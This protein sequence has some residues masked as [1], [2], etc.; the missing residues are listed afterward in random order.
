MAKV[1]DKIINEYTEILKNITFGI[2]IETCFHILG[3]HIIEDSSARKNFYNCMSRKSKD[4]PNIFQ[5]DLLSE[6]ERST[7]YDHWIIMPDTSVRCSSKLLKKKDRICMRNGVKKPLKDCDDIYFY[8]VEIVTPKLKIGEKGVDILYKVWQ[9]WLFTDNIVYTVNDSQ[10]LHINISHP[11]MNPENFLRWWTAFEPVII[12]TLP[13]S[14]R[15][16]LYTYARPISDV[17]KIGEEK[18]PDIGKNI[19]IN[20]HKNRDKITRM[21]I[22]IGQGTVDFWEAYYW[23]MLCILFLVITINLK[24]ESLDI[25]YIKHIRENPKI[26]VKELLGLISDDSIQRMI[27]N[28]YNLNKDEN[29]PEIYYKPSNKHII[30]RPWITLSEQ[31]QR[32]IYD[33]RHKMC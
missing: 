3:S 33:L 30:P 12:Q 26:M 23:L 27:I 22:R 13:L 7:T 31:E 11:D 6:D 2:E 1:T 25:S 18:I 32:D 21:E 14:R 17:Y 9:G 20:F 15:N 5:W 28:R 29:W 19:A 10:G 8:P 16:K 4:L 24:N